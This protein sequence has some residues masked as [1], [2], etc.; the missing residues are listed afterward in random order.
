MIW[1]YCVLKQ[2][3]KDG[4]WVFGIHEVYYNEK[5]GKPCAFTE[6]PVY[7]QG[8]SLEEL[9]KDLAY[10]QSDILKKKPIDVKELEKKL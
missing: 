8:A 6:E 4:S 3:Q 9:K 10:I 1:N 7:P 2:R 5:S